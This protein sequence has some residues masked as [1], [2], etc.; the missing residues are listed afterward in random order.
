MPECQ[1]CGEFVTEEYVRVFVPEN[2][3][4]PRCCPWC[5]D[6]VREDGKPRKTKSFGGGRNHDPGISD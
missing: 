4:R 1:N 6:M 2:I 5:D 3:D